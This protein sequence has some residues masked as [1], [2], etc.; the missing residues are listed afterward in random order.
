MNKEKMWP[1]ILLALLTVAVFSAGLIISLLRD[2]PS[3]SQVPMGTTFVF[4]CFTLLIVIWGGTM[5]YRTQDINIRH[6]FFWIITFLA[7]LII[8]GYVKRLAYSETFTRYLWYLSYLPLLVLPTFWLCLIL[9]SLTKINDKKALLILLSID[10][11]LF[12]IVLTNDFSG[13]TFILSEDPKKYKHGV[14]YFMIY[15]YIFLQLFLAMVIF[16]HRTIKRN[17]FRQIWPVWLVLLLIATYSVLYIL[18]NS[19]IFDIPILHTYYFVYAFFSL[20]LIEIT[21]ETGLIQNTGFYK[22]Y[23]ERSSYCLA[24]VDG[25]YNPIYTNQRFQM[26][27]EIKTT[28]N[29]VVNF[30]RYRKEKIADGYLI[31]QEDLTTLLSLQEE[32]KTKQAELRRT[33]EILKKNQKVDLTFEKI[34]TQEELLK[35]IDE[36]IVE[37]NKKIKEIVASF[38]DELTEQNRQEYLPILADLK[39]Q[40]CFLKQRCLFLINGSKNG[41]LTHDEF[42]LSMGSLLQDL[43]SLNY[44]VACSYGDEKGGKLS[45]CLKANDFFYTLV[46]SFNG[47]PGAIFLSV[48]LGKEQTKAR[49]FPSKLFKL[50]PNKLQLKKT[51]EDGDLIITMVKGK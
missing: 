50:V 21:L 12:A 19:F 42:A 28:D 1:W 7:M 15:G 4:V 6:Y 10:L 14:V 41:R 29:T 20:V 2:V 33:T 22:R 40:I 39:I 43:R 11:I 3:T 35:A 25:N 13:L 31:I 37:K 16:S 17:S 36:E 48:S 8:V 18:P 24:L 51:E 5:I 38:P 27:E 32:L 9:S 46:Q 23:F 44:Q 47:K 49:V 30:T 34:K 26:V 45:F